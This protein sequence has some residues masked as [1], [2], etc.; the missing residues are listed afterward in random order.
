MKHP[1]RFSRIGGWLWLTLFVL[2][3]AGSMAQAPA[4]GHRVFGEA[5]ADEIVMV[6]SNAAVDQQW[7]SAFDGW[8]SYLDQNGALLRV[9][10]TDPSPLAGAAGGV[11]RVALD[12]TVLWEF[13]YDQGGRLSHHDIAE[14]PNGNVLIVAWEDKTEAEAIAAG[15]DPSLLNGTF[16]PDHI[17]EV[18]QTGPTTGEIVWEWH[19]WDHL[20]QDFNP[21]R[22]NFGVVEDHPELIDINYPPES[23]FLGDW[24]H[25]N[26][27]DY[28]P[29]YDRILISAD[30][31]SEIWAI[32][33]STTT[34]EAAGH[35]G[36]R[37]GK[38]GDLLYRWGNPQ[39]YRAGTEDD[40]IFD[41]QHSP[42]VIPTGYPGEGNYTVFLNRT[43][44]QPDRS[45][46]FE[47]TPP[48]DNDGAFILDPSG[49][50]GP[51]GPL[52][53]F[54]EEGFFSAIMS[55]AE[56][57]PNGNTLIASGAQA[58]VFEVDPLGTTVWEYDE[59]GFLTQYFNA[60]YVDRWLWS[61]RSS[62]STGNGGSATFDLIAGTPYAAAD[63]LLL[64]SRS[65]SEPGV[66]I[67][68]DL[69]L[70]LNPDVLTQFLRQN[71]NSQILA[72]SAGTLNS[73]GRSQAMFNLPAGSPLR[74]GEVLHFAYVLFDPKSSEPVFVSNAVPI[75]IRRVDRRFASV[76]VA[77]G[78]IRP[79]DLPA[80]E[81]V[82]ICETFE[83]G[84]VADRAE[85]VPADLP[86]GLTV[87]GDLAD[88]RIG[89][90]VQRSVAVVESDGLTPRGRVEILALPV[91]PDLDESLILLVEGVL[92]NPLL[93]PLPREQV[94]RDEE[95]ML[96]GVVVAVREPELALFRIERPAPHPVAEL[97]DD[98][99]GLEVDL[100]R[101]AVTPE[102]EQNRVRRL[103]PN[104]RVRSHDPGDVPGVGVPDHPVVPVRVHGPELFMVEAG[105]I[106]SPDDRPIGPLV[107]P[108]MQ[109]GHRELLE[110]L[111]T[112]RHPAKRGDIVRTGPVGVLVEDQMIARLRHPG[113]QQRLTVHRFLVPD[114]AAGPVQNERP[115]V[116]L[117]GRV[118]A[119]EHEPGR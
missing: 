56:R 105:L 35:T 17:V 51:A 23:E 75:A 45:S 29:I 7:F 55:S 92:S 89:A 41:T 107:V 3:A 100:D 12:G 48:L 80:V 106:G 73:A 65:G 85:A 30:G 38:G 25:F 115:A 50:Y 116:A 78:P 21:A 82:E 112:D 103:F 110:D 26:G 53:S 60:D 74:E 10:V 57:L 101:R 46:I 31:Q 58:R 34:E 37:W 72:D 47:I 62:V 1:N 13:R 36:G 69:V 66:E 83:E 61:D 111:V 59:G 104:G 16:R 96:V 109:E 20:I 87:V 67:R 90:Q 97:A 119:G 4:P 43:P 18:R 114:D 79:A 113:N 24:N 49:S 44:G 86:D 99:A 70:P 95:R 88:P 11:E 52:W 63:Y 68:E 2:F 40:R 91:R 5:D 28:D 6:D 93:L 77:A 84:H 19:V 71:P 42:R 8:A 94:R 98:L 14:L 102:G 33:H 76:T 39:A 27:I 108:V 32:D 22:D 15:R 9:I 54:S 118:E 81:C 64:A 117:S